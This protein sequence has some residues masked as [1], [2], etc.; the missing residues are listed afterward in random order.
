MVE[1]LYT[2]PHPTEKVT[3][4]N[5]ESASKTHGQSHGLGVIK[6]NG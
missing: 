3:M 5:D 2:S 6:R 1:S 4:T